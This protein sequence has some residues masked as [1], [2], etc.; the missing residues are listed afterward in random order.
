MAEMKSYY[1]WLY[2]TVV[3]PLSAW[4]G[5]ITF[6]LVLWTWYT[7]TIGRAWRY[8]RWFREASAT[9]GERPGILVVDLS[10]KTNIAAKIERYRQH[11]PAIKEIPVIES[12]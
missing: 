10:P 2:E 11:N 12:S 8:R 4:S 3:N 7:I 5:L 1:N 6:V 9:L